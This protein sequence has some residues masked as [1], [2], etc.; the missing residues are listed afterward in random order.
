MKDSL[1]EFLIETMKQLKEFLKESLEKFQKQWIIS[2]EI[3][4]KVYEGNLWIFFDESQQE[5][6]KKPPKDLLKKKHF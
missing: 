2:K 3:R 4:R 1:L 6:L 5:F